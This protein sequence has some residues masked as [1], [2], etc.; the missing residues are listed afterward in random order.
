MTSDT[1]KYGNHR[2]KF[3]NSKTRG[4]IVFK[5]K[6]K[7]T[8]SKECLQK[9]LVSVVAIDRELGL[10]ALM[11]IQGCKNSKWGWRDGSA[12]K[13]TD[14]SSTGSEFNSQ[15]TTWWLTTICNGIQCPFWCV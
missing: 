2:L 1:E 3:F 14:C 8:E 11:G 6:K 7:K 9:S 10:K 12:V 15:P 5:K 4:Q 13:S